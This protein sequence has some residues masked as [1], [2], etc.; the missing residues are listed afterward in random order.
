MNLEC[1]TPEEALAANLAVK[2]MSKEEKLAFLANLEED[3]ILNLQPVVNSI[4]LKWQTVKATDGDYANPVFAQ[5]YVGYLGDEVYAFG[6]SF[7]KNNGK[8][9]NVF[10][11]VNREATAYDLDDVS[12]L[13]YRQTGNSKRQ[14]TIARTSPK[15]PEYV[16]VDSADQFTES[17]GTSRAKVVNLHLHFSNLCNMKCIMCSSRY[18]NQWYQDEEKLYGSKTIT[19]DSLSL[20]IAS[21]H[22]IFVQYTTWPLIFDSILRRTSVPF[23]KLSLPTYAI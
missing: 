13:L 14:N 7:T 10:P 18:S 3:R 5:N 21:S 9:T 22:G 19:L 12:D 15:I 1:L 6:I 16:T 17:D 11:F 2:D 20:F 8:Q 23:S 4:P